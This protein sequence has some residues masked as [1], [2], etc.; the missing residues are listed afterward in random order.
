MSKRWGLWVLAVLVVLTGCEDRDRPVIADGRLTATPGGVDLQRVAMFD[1]REVEVVLRN[2]GRARLNVDEAWVEGAAGAWQV[3]FTHEG[4]HALV[5]G[6]ECVLRVRFNPQQEGALPATL[7]VRS[8]TLKDPVVRVPLQGVGVDA[9]ARVSP[10][11]LDFGRIELESTK[12]LALTVSNPTDLPVEVTPKL[13]GAQKDEFVAEPLVLGPN[14]ERELP[15]T[16]APTKAGL[17][18]VALAV[19]PC[20]GCADVAVQVS[21]EGL[22]RAVVAEPAELDFGSI[23]VDQERVRPL[24]LHNLSTEPMT[25]TSLTLTSTEASFTHGPPP[26]PL[27]L[28]PGEVRTWDFRYSP[29]HMGP[30]ENLASFRVESRR[31]PT[32]DVPLR[33]FGGAAEL[34]VSPLSHDFGRQPLGAKVARIINVKNCGAANGGPLTIHGLELQP[35]DGSTGADNGLHLVPATLP[36]RL[37]PGEEVNLKVF[38]EPVRE[39][40]ATSRLV[41]RTDVYSGDTTTLNF[42][43]V[44]EQHGPCRV[45]YTPVAVD[46]GTVQPGRGAVLG[47]KVDNPGGDLCAVKNIRMR[48]TGGGVFSLPGGE[49][50]GV[51]VYPGD[52]FSFMVAFAAPLTG[53][54]TGG[55]FLGS[56]QIEQWD[57]ANPL[58]TIPLKGHTQNT[59]LVV[60]PRYVDYGV[61]RPDCSPAPREVN[62]INGCQA[63]LTV[64]D[65]RI[66]AGTSDGEFVL[67]ASPPTPFTLAPGDAFTVSVDYLAQVF[68]LNLSPLF[69]ASSDLPAPMLVPLVGESSRRLDKTDQFIQ[70]DGAKVDVLFVVD[71][72]ASMVEEQPR[73]EA[74]MPA[75]VE[76][77]L[78]KGVDLNI[79]VTTTG[80]DPGGTGT[81]PGGVQGAEAGRFFPVVGGGPRIL[82]RQTPDLAAVLRNNVNVGQCAAVEQGFEA[83]RRALSPPLVTS[84]DDVRTPEPNDGNRGF[85]RDEAALVVVFVGDEDDHS[86]DSVD[87][88]V[89]FLQARKGENQPQRMTLYAIAPTAEGCPTSGGGGT[90]YAEAAARTGGEVLSICSADYSPLMRSVANKAFS[91]QD[92]FPLSEQPDPGSIAVSVNGTRV[93]EGWSYDGATNSVVFTA[94]PAAGA[95]V[96]I[97]YRRACE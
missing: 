41:M 60:S 5:P 76:A 96:E 63:P 73:L 51:V 9:W 2:V 32:T 6:S 26:L 81:C 77:A 13:L 37:R 64:S 34:C 58:V 97:Y 88:Y 59:C 48:D 36:Y 29:G 35:T 40:T 49:L 17:K 87:T 95:K 8:D 15:I 12:R 79:A 42:R 25:V 70:Q 3:A 72:T 43:G 92:R 91:P 31:N 90:R 57:P 4:P 50:D 30:A 78:A 94:A 56:V 54:E 24:R 74:S 71:N 39:G 65:V 38:F 55:D 66:G 69:V 84:A 14:E 47:V 23:P 83:V 1:G 18:Q 89:R 80:I 19:S 93:T 86:P 75:F 62:Y 10:R 27:V 52:S 46:F 53:G 28:G 11:K 67:R 68:G 45:D 22:D 21:A 61:S 85:L 44:A 82:N 16:F 7:V 33:G 20:K